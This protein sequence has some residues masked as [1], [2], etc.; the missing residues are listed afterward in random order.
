MKHYF[1]PQETQESRAYQSAHNGLPQP[2]NGIDDIP[3]YS[4]IDGVITRVESEQYPVGRQ[5]RIE[6]NNQSG[7]A[8]RL[9]HIWPREGLDP[10]N[11]QPVQ[12][13]VKAGE[14]I[15]VIAAAQGTDIAVQ[16]G[17]GKLVSYFELLPDALF[18]AYQTRGV[19]SRADL[20]LTKEYRDAHAVACEKGGGQQFTLPAG[21]DSSKEDYVY[22]SGYVAPV[23]NKP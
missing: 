14:K 17:W 21:Y 11:N 6:A 13:P 22:L 9:F 23:E 10:G 19:Q 2:P 3:I 20:I 4:P 12:I 18:A 8:I 7:Y 1:R 16:Q 15:G 5:I